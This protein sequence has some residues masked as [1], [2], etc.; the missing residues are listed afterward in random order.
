M[1]NIRDTC[2]NF[3]KDEDIKRNIKEII[4]PI[5]DIIY[6]ELYVYI[7]F[8]CIYTVILIFLVL[9]ILLLLIFVLKNVK[10]FRNIKIN[11]L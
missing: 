7:W 4:H 10:E 11:E 8:V 2:I 3:L 5:S 9:I 6:N 1:N